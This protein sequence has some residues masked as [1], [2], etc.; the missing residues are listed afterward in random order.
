M[1]H[2]GFS[3]SHVPTVAETRI[4]VNGRF[5]ISVRSCVGDAS[6]QRDLSRHHHR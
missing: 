5:P 1:I 4:S 6:F 3:Y 2:H